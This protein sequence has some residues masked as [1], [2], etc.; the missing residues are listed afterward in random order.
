MVFSTEKENCK[1]IVEAHKTCIV[2]DTTEM[3]CKDEYERPK[4]LM[5][6][7][8]KRINRRGDKSCSIKTPNIPRKIS[9]CKDYIQKTSLKE[10]PKSMLGL[11]KTKLMPSTMN[12]E[13][14]TLLNTLSTCERTSYIVNQPTTR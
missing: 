6:S 11:I 14:V 13:Y 5:N 9:N 7:L 10:T 1:Q 3:A 12:N 2:H 8:G 4:G